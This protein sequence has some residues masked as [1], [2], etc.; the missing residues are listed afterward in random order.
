[1][2]LMEIYLKGILT[3]KDREVTEEL[4]GTPFRG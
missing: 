4:R 1:L 3:R 2:A